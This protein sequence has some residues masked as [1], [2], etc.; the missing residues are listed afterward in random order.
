MKEKKDRTVAVDEDTHTEL[1]IMA[2]KRKIAIKQV[3]KEIVDF[4][5]EKM[6]KNG[7]KQDVGKA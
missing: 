1:A 7:N 4:Y 2:A 3:F 6:A 5:I